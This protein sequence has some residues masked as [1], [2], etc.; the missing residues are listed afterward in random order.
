MEVQFSPYV[1][2][3]LAELSA[4]FEVKLTAMS[5]ASAGEQGLQKGKL[6]PKPKVRMEAYRVGREVFSFVTT[7]INT[8]SRSKTR[9]PCLWQPFRD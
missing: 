8:C 7:S 5:L 3:R 6:L 1:A 4:T 9:S 2:K